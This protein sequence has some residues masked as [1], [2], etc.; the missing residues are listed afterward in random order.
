M[1]ATGIG[2]KAGAAGVDSAGVESRG[3]GAVPMRRATI[4]LAAALAIPTG[5]AFAKPPATHT[6]H[7]HAT[8]NVMYVLQGMLSAYQPATATTDGEVTITVKHSNYHGRALKNLPVTFTVTTKTRIRFRH[9]STTIADDSNG[10]ITVRAPKKI[11]GDLA[12]MLP[13]AASRLHVLVLRTPA[14]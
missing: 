6:N 2:I 14:P 3:K 12:T 11:S 10:V 13:D 4:L 9:G 7:S 8:P 1:A 5:V